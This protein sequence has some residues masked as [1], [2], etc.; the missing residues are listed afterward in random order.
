MLLFSLS[1][2]KLKLYQA[3]LSFKLVLPHDLYV[4]GPQRQCADYSSW[5]LPSFISNHFSSPRSCAPAISVLFH[6]SQTHHFLQASVVLHKLAPLPKMA[7]EFPFILHCLLLKFPFSVKSSP[8][9]LSDHSY[10]L[11]TLC[12]PACLQIRTLSKTRSCF[13]LQLLW[14]HLAKRGS[15]KIHKT[16]CNK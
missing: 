8:P 11:I 7:S 12:M 9:P 16:H 10:H 15:E 14:S 1:S 5:L 4:V 2:L 3:L 13:H 6:F